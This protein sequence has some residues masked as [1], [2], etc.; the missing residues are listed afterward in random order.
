MHRLEHKMSSVQLGWYPGT[1]GKQ[2]SSSS[3]WWH[4]VCHVPGLCSSFLP[5]KG[6]SAS[7]AGSIPLAQFPLHV[8]VLEVCPLF[9][10]IM[11]GQFIRLPLH[12]RTSISSLQTGLRGFSLQMHRQAANQRNHAGQSVSCDRA[13]C[14]LISSQSIL[15]TLGP[16]ARGDERAVSTQHPQCALSRPP[17]CGGCDGGSGG[18][19]G[20]DGT[21]GS[22]GLQSEV[23][24]PGP[25][26]HRGSPRLPQLTKGHCCMEGSHC[27]PVG[28]WCCTLEK[29]QHSLRTQS[30]LRWGCSPVGC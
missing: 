25:S 18:V 27:L 29:E 3:G 28:S 1:A 22:A 6:L 20:S 19:G 8:S 9:H 7:G 4:L 13:V 16:S 17:A 30:R 15:V 23:G 5:V 26:R 12:Y 10:S 2:G 14:R 24:C 11:A 21:C